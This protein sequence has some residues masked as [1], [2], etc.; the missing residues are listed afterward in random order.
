MQGLKINGFNVNGFADPRLAL[1]YLQDGTSYCDVIISDV[2]MP[3]M[4]GFQFVRAIKELVPQMKVIIMSSFEIKKSEF[5]KVLP[6][7][8]V[9]A[10]ICKPFELNALV[11]TIKKVNAATQVKT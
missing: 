9:D 2:R 6:H 4:N 7:T 5:E 10:F 3:T 1:H 8:H 11:E